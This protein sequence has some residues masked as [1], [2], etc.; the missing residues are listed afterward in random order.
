MMVVYRYAIIFYTPSK[1]AFAFVCPSASAGGTA[2]VGLQT[3]N[4]KVCAYLL[5]VRLNVVSHF[6]TVFRKQCRALS[7]S[8]SK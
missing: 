1:E 4:C 7:S 8:L 6:K 2:N 5:F 3:L